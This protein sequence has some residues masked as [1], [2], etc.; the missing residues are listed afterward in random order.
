MSKEGIVATMAVVGGQRDK[1]GRAGNDQ[2][3]MQQ[4]Q[5]G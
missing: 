3:M 1:I 5:S 2:R 4:E